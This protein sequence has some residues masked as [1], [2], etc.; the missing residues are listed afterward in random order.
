MLVV[1]VLDEAKLGNRKGAL[2]EAIT[3]ERFANEH[4]RRVGG[5]RLFDAMLN[6]VQGKDEDTAEISWRVTGYLHPTEVYA[7]VRADS[8]RGLLTFTVDERDSAN[9][10]VYIT[11]VE[12]TVRLGGERMILQQ[13]A[14]LVSDATAVDQALDDFVRVAQPEMQEG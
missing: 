11:T 6:Q 14:E 9:S 3:Y 10:D 13:G 5:Q 7:N 1:N 2:M 4:A 8:E 12:F